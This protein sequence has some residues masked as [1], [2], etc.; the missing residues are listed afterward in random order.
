M[1]DSEKPK[2]GDRLTGCKLIIDA[3]DAKTI[4][5]DQAERLLDGLI[6]P[7]HETT[8][9]SRQHH[10]QQRAGAMDDLDRADALERAERNQPPSELQQAIDADLERQTTPTPV[11]PVE[12]GQNLLEDPQD[13]VARA[14]EA[15][16]RRAA[17]TSHR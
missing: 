9:I 15:R 8:Q 3:L 1:T 2:L 7:Q 13:F 17:G 6:P 11:R 12:P 4:D 14:A 16:A 10:D 5:A